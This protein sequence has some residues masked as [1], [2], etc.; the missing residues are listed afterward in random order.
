MSVYSWNVSLFVSSTAGAQKFS[1]F[2][3]FKKHPPPFNGTCT[4]DK[5]EGFAASSLFNI[6]CQD[7]KAYDCEISF[8]SFFCM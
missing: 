5:S 4:V 1:T 6:V 8:Y 2:S 7:F 3:Y